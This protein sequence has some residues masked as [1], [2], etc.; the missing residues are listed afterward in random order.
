MLLGYFGVLTAVYLEIP[1]GIP[2][3]RLFRDAAVFQNGSHQIRPGHSV[4]SGWWWS[5]AV[6]FGWNMMKHTMLSMVI[7]PR[8]T[9]VLSP[10]DQ[11]AQFMTSGTLVCANKNPWFDHPPFIL[12]SAKST[13]SPS[14]TNGVSPTWTAQHLILSA[15][16]PFCF[17]GISVSLAGWPD[18][19]AK[20]ESHGPMEGLD[21]LKQSHVLMTW[22]MSTSNIHPHHFS[23]YEQN[24]TKHNKNLVKCGRFR[25]VQ[26]KKRLKTQQNTSRF[27]IQKT[28]PSAPSESAE[29]PLAQDIAKPIAVTI[30]MWLGSQKVRPG[31]GI[32]GR[33]GPKRCLQRLLWLLC[34]QRLLWLLWLLIV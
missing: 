9:R 24:I 27:I 5:S 15:K 34:L 32:T 33:P 26:P 7:L 29:F 30:Q 1:Q 11:V 12:Y 18:M 10:W 14:W 13:I 31:M 20:L 28:P 2:V 3:I 17:L 6:F 25:I 23:K 21:H 8:T 4:A 16:C 22:Y 19:M